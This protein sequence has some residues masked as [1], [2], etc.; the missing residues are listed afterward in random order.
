MD[1][2]DRLKQLSA[3][4]A[5][6]VG[7]LETEEATKTALVLPFI[8][9]LGYIFDPT[10]VIPEFVADVGVKKGEKVDYAIVLNEVPTILFECK[11]LRSTGGRPALED[12]DERCKVPLSAEDVAALEKVLGAIER[13]SGAKPS[14]GQIASVILRANLEA[15]KL[16]ADKSTD[17]LIT[18]EASGEP[19]EQVSLAAVN[20]LIEKQ[21]KPIREELDR[22]AKKTGVGKAG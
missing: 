15:L 22:V 13:T 21:L 11:A 12:A 17:R 5:E 18:G 8:Q 2:I 19:D 16:A 9:A 6:R 20:D 3:N 4:A 7:H 14:L 10:E 1:L